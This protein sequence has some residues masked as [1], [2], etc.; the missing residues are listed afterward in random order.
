MAQGEIDVKDY[1]SFDYSAF[2]IPH[3]DSVSIMLRS[4][5]TNQIA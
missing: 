5:N 2:I 1:E 3:L 4:I